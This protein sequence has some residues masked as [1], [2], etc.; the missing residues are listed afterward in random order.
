M[1]LAPNAECLAVELSLP[2]LTPYV[3]RGLFVFTLTSRMRGEWFTETGMVQ[4]RFKLSLFKANP[5]IYST[6]QQ[7][8]ALRN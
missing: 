4:P 1:T 5:S 2:V 8:R 3:C 7:H 6:N